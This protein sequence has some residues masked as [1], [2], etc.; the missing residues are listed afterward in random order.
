[1]EAILFIR[2]LQPKCILGVTFMDR[3]GFVLDFKNKTFKP[4]DLYTVKA[5]RQ[6]IIPPWSTAAV[7]CK[8]DVS[9]TG[10]VDPYDD[11]MAST[12]QAAIINSSNPNSFPLLLQNNNP[13]PL[14]IARDDNVGLF[15]PT[16]EEDIIEG[17][18]ALEML[19]SQPKIPLIKNLDNEKAQMLYNIPISGDNQFITSLRNLIF[20][21]HDVF[22]MGEDDLGRA[23]GVQHIIKMRDE[24]PVHVKQFRI[25]DAH[26]EFINSRVDNLL[27]TK[28]IVPSSSTFNHPIFAVKK[29]NNSL[30]F[31][32]DMRSLND[33]SYDSKY[34][35]RDVQACID[36]VGQA[37][38]VI[39][40]TLDVQSA[41]HQL[42]LHPQSRHLTAFTVPS[43]ARYEWCVTPM[44][45]KG[46]PGSWSRFMDLMMEGL[47]N[48]SH[49][50][51]DVLIFSASTMDH[52]KHLEAVFQKLRR[53]NI[54]ISINKAKFGL[55]KV[56][57]VGH[58][59]SKDG[60]MPGQNKLKAVA[61]FP[62]PS[63]V[64]QVREW[65]GLCNF[66]RQYIK[67]YSLLA[68]RLTALTRKDATWKSGPLPEDAN[69]A[70]LKLKQLLCSSPVLA[71]PNPNFPYNLHVDAATGSAEK[72]DSPEIKG[73]LG[74]VLTQTQPDGG[75]KVIA[76]ASRSL[77]KHEMNYSPFLLE[78][79]CIE[80][81]CKHFHVY[82][83]AKHF[84]VY[85]DHA[86]LEKLSHLHQKTLNR[87]N[88]LKNEYSFDVVYIKGS[89]NTA[90]DALSRNPVTAVQAALPPQN[91][92]TATMDI[93]REQFKKAQL[94]DPLL[95][96][97][98][99]TI[100]G[101]KRQYHNKHEEKAIDNWASNCKIL[102]DLLFF[103]GP[104][105][106]HLLFVP[107]S[108]REMVAKL[109]HEH[110]LAGHG[111]VQ[112][113]ITRIRERY[114]WPGIAE[115]V[116]KIV[117][118]CLTCQKST[119]P[120]SAQLRPPLQPH[121]P[122]QLPLQHIHID[123]MGPYLTE[124]GISKYIMVMVCAF[125]KWAQ[126]C[127]LPNK[128]ALTVAKALHNH[129]TA[130]LGVPEI[131]SS[132]RGL[133]FSNKIL[134]EL[135][136]LLNIKRKL[137]ASFN[138]RSNAVAESWNRSLIAYIKKGLDGRSSLHWQQ[139][140]NDMVLSYNTTKHS[141]TG[142]SPYQ[143]L[144]GRL[145]FMPN[146]QIINDPNTW[147]Q[148]KAMDIRAARSMATDNMITMN[149][150]NKI[151]YDQQTTH[152][153]FQPGDKVM[154]F[155]PRSSLKDP[156]G[157]KGNPKFLQQWRPNCTIS[158]VLGPY[159]YLVR[160]QGRGRPSVV[161]VDRIKPQL[162]QHSPVYS[163]PQQQQQQ[164]Q[165]QQGPGGEEEEE[166]EVPLRRSERIRRKKQ[167]SAYNAKERTPS[168][169]IS[170][171]IAQEEAPQVLLQQPIV[172][173]HSSSSSSASSTSSSTYSSSTNTPIN[174]ANSSDDEEDVLSST[175]SSAILQIVSPPSSS[176]S[177]SPSTI[178][179]EDSFNIP[180]ANS[181]ADAAVALLGARPK[182]PA[183]AIPSQKMDDFALKQRTRSATI[184]EM[185]AI[186]R[187]L[188]RNL[189]D[190][191]RLHQPSTSR[192][193]PPTPSR[194]PPTV[195]KQTTVQKVS[196]ALDGLVQES[197]L[198]GSVSGR[199]L[200]RSAHKKDK[201]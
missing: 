70:F 146:F 40:S 138:P 65:C 130:F 80:W 12:F 8:C 112:R 111:G 127:L 182:L 29:A 47:N 172:V 185:Q 120:P 157:K 108:Q 18:K 170:F 78:K 33:A 118:T 35:I 44:G 61:D 97:I 177:S 129:W 198:P 49:Y 100:Q 197:V 151:R 173:A 23:M 186:A 39:F 107:A 85:T 66:F 162:E 188:P 38:P 10:I 150:T 102:N 69:L 159:T 56:N 50:L 57:F 75:Q 59:L 37:H 25:P 46:A 192:P 91:K 82:L 136:T 14:I 139:L 90:A 96:A 98:I 64:R 167:V 41:F 31:V 160:H 142:F 121:M 154:V 52:I 201:K 181:A 165:Q 109:H 20:Q 55:E 5:T 149:E 60:S 101:W 141:A 86:P 88:E 183:A 128:E 163:Q 178:R 17:K 147:P 143:L 16:E 124:S 169:V 117:T 190:D 176:S 132:D 189:P 114:F 15:T 148:Q 73:G 28:R 58:T 9:G 137:T 184:A 71:Y 84:T 166:E 99:E 156:S 126:A 179:W 53:F 152:R 195:S 133:E 63:T 194:P 27:E 153:T 21:Y 106:E 19:Q 32:G 122:P 22:S 6:T 134:D 76:Y 199:A 11:I 158:K 140:L 26:L 72:E 34:V 93:S 113:T 81:A 155:Y 131:I 83:A 77:E 105:F 145:P 67:N 200:T 104:S 1:M 191:S 135:C 123:L 115:D 168:L 161:N 164:P 87:L 94:E 36:K 125:S 3:Y 187:T 103:I 45:C 68:S 48:T 74:A 89:D 180:D 171:G 24:E 119:T 4:A 7:N 175:P 116:Q 110:T 13:E 62:P 51:D 196:R 54:K 42:P 174:S 193:P 30:R 92:Q 79:K 43:R 144:F 95:L 2:D